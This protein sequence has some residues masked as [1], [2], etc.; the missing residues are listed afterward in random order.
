MASQ[1]LT[2][3]LHRKAIEAGDRWAAQLLA[4]PRAHGCTAS[5]AASAVRELARSAFTL[6]A[7]AWGPGYDVSGWKWPFTALEEIPALGVLPGRVER[8]FDGMQP[9]AV[10]L[11]TAVKH[12]LS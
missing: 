6:Y 1:P 5:G 9:W 2:N 3:R 7:I 10:L 11:Q 12:A 4:D 8:P